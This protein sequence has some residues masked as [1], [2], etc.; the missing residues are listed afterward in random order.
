MGSA[1]HYF[2]TRWKQKLRCCG[3][4]AGSGGEETS[5]AQGPGWTTTLFRDPSQFREEVVQVQADDLG[6]LHQFD[7]VEPALAG[8]VLR[9]EGLRPPQ[10][11]GDLLDASGRPDEALAAYRRSLWLLRELG[12]AHAPGLDTMKA[13]VARSS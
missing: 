5:S 4:C 2:N 1:G 6:D 8:L 12:V 11:L 3:R 13:R 7:D 9:H 10:A